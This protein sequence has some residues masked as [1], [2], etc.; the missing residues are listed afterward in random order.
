MHI[1]LADN[2]L[3]RD[4][5]PCDYH[6]L[7]DNENRPVKWMALESILEYEYSGASDVVSLSSV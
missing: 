1:K 2:A 5:F 6:C 3:S 4:I 7:D